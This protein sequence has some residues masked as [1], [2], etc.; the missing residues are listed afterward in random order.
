MPYA[1]CIP[2]TGDPEVLS[3]EEISVGDPDP[4][5]VRLRRAAAGVNYRSCR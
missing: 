5:Q 2:R 1:I 3:R 4:G